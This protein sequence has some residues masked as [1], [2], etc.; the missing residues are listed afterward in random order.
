MKERKWEF[1]LEV[2]GTES[3]ARTVNWLMS[4][5]DTAIACQ[6]WD[7]AHE[8]LLRASASPKGQLKLAD[9]YLNPEAELEIPATERQT[10][11]K[12]LLLGLANEEGAYAADACLMLA[13]LCGGHPLADVSYRLKVD[14]LK[15]GGVDGTKIQQLVPRIRRLENDD[16]YGAYKL[17]VEL[18]H[19][20]GHNDVL[21][22][23]K[24]LYQIAA[25]AENSFSGIAALRLSE[26]Y[27]GDP[28][29]AFKYIAEKKGFPAILTRN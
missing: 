15:N 6:D 26:I 27:D 29:T 9:L 3:E 25:E 21:S 14:R 8:L 18:D 4:L 28:C 23:K 12:Q 13:S 24:E 22:L 16:A 11:A 19:Y 10:K 1:D 20:Q 5:S 17:A 2:E 7:S